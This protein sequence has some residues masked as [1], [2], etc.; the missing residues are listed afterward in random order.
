MQNAW[1]S[2]SQLLDYGALVL[3]R[4]SRTHTSAAPARIGVVMVR[5]NVPEAPSGHPRCFA[6][7]SLP[8]PRDTLLTLSE[9]ATPQPERAS[10]A[11]LQL[12]APAAFLAAE[13]VYKALNSAALAAPPLSRTLFDHGRPASAAA[14]DPSIENSFPSGRY[15]GTLSSISRADEDAMDADQETAF[16]AAMS[17]PVTV[18]RGAPGTGKSMVARAIVTHAAAKRKPLACGLSVVLVIYSSEAEL[19]AFLQN[20][21]EAGVPADAMLRLGGATAE[22][23][24]DRQN[25]LQRPGWRKFSREA[26]F[27]TMTW[28]QQQRWH[29]LCRRTTQTGEAAKAAISHLELVRFIPSSFP[30]YFYLTNVL[31]YDTLQ[32]SKQKCFDLAHEWRNILHR[33]AGARAAAKQCFRRSCSSSAGMAPA[34]SPLRRQRLQSLRSLTLSS[35]A[36]SHLPPSKPKLIPFICKLMSDFRE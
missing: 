16:A 2:A 12:A 10:V 6:W 26:V 14:A 3:L 4:P 31:G 13:A 36:S 29:D 11:I 9:L 30:S 17:H 28:P 19:D 33:S 32:E 18:I 25:V 22:P 1:W 7:L 20:L 35:C 34:G 23:L 5:D 21:L 8:S 15:S 24:L 27:P